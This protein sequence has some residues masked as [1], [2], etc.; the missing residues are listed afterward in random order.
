MS[1]III[2]LQ[3]SLLQEVIDLELPGDVML[4]NLLPELA[5]A[6]KLPLADGAGQAITY[7]LVHQA[8]PRP[9]QGTDTLANAGVVTGDVL[10]LVS[11]ASPIG[12]GAGGI[13]RG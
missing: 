11:A 4:Q 9:L 5:R 7:Q 3:S 8:W 2:T 1:S 12:A 10:S 6:L 13:S